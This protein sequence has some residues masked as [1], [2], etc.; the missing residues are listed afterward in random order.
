MF[1]ALR[2]TAEGTPIGHVCVPADNVLHR[3]IPLIRENSQ[4][5][6][7]IDCL[8]QAAESSA[9]R[10]AHE[11]S[12]GLQVMHVLRIPRLVGTS[13][14]QGCKDTSRGG[15]LA[16]IP[17]KDPGTHTQARRVR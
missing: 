8:V 17:G 7:F 10:G 16:R 13:S 11:V 3:C 4:R 6:E 14:F 9:A 2:S 1:S 12:L 5:E 15:L